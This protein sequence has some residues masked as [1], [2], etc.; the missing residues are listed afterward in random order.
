MLSSK[1]LSKYHNL[2]NYSDIEAVG[3]WDD[4]HS[5]EDIHTICNIVENPET[6]EEVVLIFHNRP[7]LCGSEVLDPYDGKTYTIPERVGTLLEGFRYWYQVGQSKEGFLSVH[8]CY[9]Y[10][11]PIT[12]KVLPKCVIPKDKWEDTFIQSKIQYFDRPTPKGAK[13]PHGLQAYALRM[14]IHKPDIT[15]FTK[16]NA[17]MLHRVIEDC[18]TQK[19]TSEYLKTEREG[20]KDRIGIDFTEAYKMEVDYAITCQ[21]QEVY[22]ALIDEPHVQRCVDTWDVRLNSLEASIE[23]M[24]PPT[25]KPQGQKITRKELAIVLGYSDKIVQQIEEPTELVNRNG[26]R[27]EVKIKPYYNPFTN[28]HT[29]K[30]VN[31]Y[32][33]F[34]ISY[35]FSPVCVKKSDLTKWI[36]ENYPDT[37]PKDWD[38]SKDVAETKLLNANT[39]SYFNLEPEDTNLIAGAFTRVKFTPSKLTQHEIVKGELIKAGVKVAEEW[40]L[41][42]DLEGQINKADFDT[43][44]SYPKK[45]APENQMH[46]RVKKGD[47]LVTSPK[48]SEKDLD[49]V[50]GELGHEIKE[51]NTTM[52]RRRYLSNPKDPDNKGI[53]ALIREDGRVSAGINN[54]GTSTGRGSHRIIVNLPSESALLGKEMR[55]CI[56]APEGKELVGI[57]QKSSQLSIASFVT[58]NEQYYDAVASGVEFKNDEEGNQ[59][60]VGTSAHCLNARYFNLVTEGE[61]KQA[62]DEQ[63]ENLVHDIVLRRKKSK[64]LSFASLFGCG[65]KKLAVMGGFSEPEA[66]TKLKSFLDNIGL[67]DVINFLEQCSVKYKRGRGFYIPSAFGYWIYCEGMHKAVNFLIQSIEAAVQKKAIMLF[68]EQVLQRGWVGSVNKIL[69]QHDEVLLEVD[70]GMGV[71]VG[72]VMCECYTEAGKLLNEYYNNNLHLYSGV[73]TPKIICDFA[74]GYAVGRSYA[75]CH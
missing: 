2:P 9:G 6:K 56:V 20:L 74:G 32:S 33:G 11:R 53:L 22:G 18:R 38:I 36:K 7:D 55:M 1:Q 45:A 70:K 49:Q 62:V 46:I 51:Y 61:W 5:L 23:P 29:T 59:V 48:F 47:A 10:D 24:L 40:N 69:D 15:D 43:V 30:K 26:E 3:F 65:A 68:D 39:C 41:S 27:V 31:Q 28:Y 75:E 52:H 19:Y 64:G 14:G 54:F 17:F 50:V 42:R 35:G 44:V 13:S 4:V 12:E 16:M 60:Y 57:D 34:H 67:T 63:T 73:G 71:E 25:V 21:K 8:N 72:T 58:N 37:K 66:K